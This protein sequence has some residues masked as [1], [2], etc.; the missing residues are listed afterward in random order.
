M[1]ISNNQHSLADHWRPAYFID[2]DVTEP[3]VNKKTGLNKETSGDKKNSVDESACVYKK[4]IGYFA[5]NHAVSVSELLKCLS[6]YHLKLNNM[7][8][9]G[10]AIYCDES[11]HFII[12]LLAALKTKRDIVIL[13]NKQPATVNDLADQQY[14]ILTDVIYIR[15]L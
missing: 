13:P 5:D 1:L 6:A 9:R 7:A 4:I 10:W 11:I 3:D 14:T 8:C 12:A 2:I 15:S